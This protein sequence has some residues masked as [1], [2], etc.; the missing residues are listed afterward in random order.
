MISFIDPWAV[1][2]DDLGNPLVGRVNFYDIGTS[3]LKN[4]YKA[5]GVAAENPVYT[6]S[7]GKL[8]YQ[9]FLGVGDYTASFERYIGTAS[10]MKAIGVADDPMQWFKYKEADL[11]GG[12]VTSD[13]AN[14]SITVNTIDELR[15]VDTALY[16][17]C[18]VIGY[19]AANDNIPSRTYIWNGAITS[20]DNYGT[21]IQRTGQSVGRWQMQQ[22]EEMNVKY[23]GIFPGSFTYNSQLSALIVWMSTYGLNRSIRFG[24]GTYTFLAGTFN[25]IT[26]VILEQNVKFNISGTRTLNI[27]FN[28]DYDIQTVNPLVINT[29]A[30]TNVI[31]SFGATNASLNNQI[32]KS[33]W[34]GNWSDSV[35]GDDA[36]INAME[37]RV[38]S[39]YT[40]HADAT[41]YLKSM[42]NINH[43]TVFNNG[44][45]IAKGGIINFNIVDLSNIGTGT[46]LI[47]ST[48]GAWTNYRFIGSTVRASCFYGYPNLYLD[49][50]T[51]SSNSTFIFD[52]SVTFTGQFMDNGG[53]R[54]VHNYG[55]ISTQSAEV[56]AQFQRIECN[57]NMFGSVCYVAINNQP[58]KI[59]WFMP[60]SYSQSQGQ[61]A[62]INATRCA[63]MGSGHLD[64]CNKN[65]TVTAGFDILGTNP[66]NTSFSITNGRITTTADLTLLTF[67]YPCTKLEIK[68]ILYYAP[69][70]NT[71][72]LTVEKDGIV[73]AT[74]GDLIIRDSKFYL[75]LSSIMIQTINAGNI[76]TLKMDNNEV[77]MDG[78]WMLANPTLTNCFLTNNK[79]K[80]QVTAQN[81][82]AKVSNN[83]FDG[84]DRIDFT[85]NNSLIIN[86]N[87]LYKTDLRIHANGAVIDAVV[88]GN[89]FEST[90]DK[91]SRIIIQSEALGT[92]IKGCVITGN[93]FTG[94]VT[95]TM[96]AIMFEG[97]FSSDW[98][99][100]DVD[101]V[102]YGYSS[103]HICNVVGNTSSHKNIKVPTTKGM[104]RAPVDG[105]NGQS[106]SAIGVNSWRYYMPIDA[107]KIF[108]IP[109]STYAV[110]TV[111][112]GLVG[113][114]NGSVQYT[115]NNADSVGGSFAQYTSD[116]TFSVYS[117]GSAP[118]D[119][120]NVS[121]EIYNIQEAVWL[122]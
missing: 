12:A 10:N 18:T 38:H 108:Y 55:I 20:T 113:L 2:I 40:I 41:Y 104:V 34:Y 75:S 94:D 96:L 97:T 119:D 76:V 59:T 121:F 14:S 36:S 33:T 57:N 95:S 22:P 70:N 68:D 74:I 43:N 46:P 80:A 66:D 17:Q 100:T 109:G 64:L 84:C 102:R 89:Q 50:Q 5:G 77:T 49:C 51:N 7:T 122:I 19:Y 45:Y 87:R 115:P 52:K 90:N 92:I 67:K 65:I 30:L 63:M 6:D 60:N 118:L 107:N 42:V 1:L 8:E 88:T 71:T 26:K 4:V 37:A 83:E 72:F 47:T 25:F 15:L 106:T 112:V 86:N 110:S 79:I 13:V 73:N 78:G 120:F 29:N 56:Y 28:A 23:F 82:Y 44:Q 21:I 62:L 103:V 11:T 31:V 99:Y 93:G 117:Q 81:S 111:P 35:N 3:E 27:N 54:Y 61:T 114:G 32:V 16:N 85:C 24:T 58:T 39:G 9:V 101:S 53:F 48:G 91:Y 98:V 105:L 116:G 69:S